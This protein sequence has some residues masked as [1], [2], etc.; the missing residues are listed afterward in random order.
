LTA[1]FVDEG[2]RNYI[3][4]QKQRILAAGTVT[5][6]FLTAGMNLGLGDREVSFIM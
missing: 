6:W 4:H 5:S 3:F 1:L 2:W